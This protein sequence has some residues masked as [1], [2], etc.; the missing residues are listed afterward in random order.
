MFQTI[1][2]IALAAILLGLILFVPPLNTMLYGGIQ[3]IRDQ[4]DTRPERRILFIG[5]SRTFYNDM[6]EMVRQMSGEAGGAERLHIEMYAKSGVSLE[7]HWADPQ[8]QALLGQGWD[9]VV[10]QAQSTAQ[11][12]AQHSGR[13]WQTAEQFIDKARSVGAKPVMFVTWRY[14]AFC[15][16]GM[17]IPGAG[18]TLPASGLPNMHRNIQLQHARLAETTGVELV[19]VGALW[20]SLQDK[21]AIFHLYAD[22]NHPSVYGSY[23][24]ALMFFNYFTGGTVADVAYRPEWMPEERASYIRQFVSAYLGQIDG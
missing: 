19:N 1:R 11:Y 5:N 7:T 9:D 16:P 18:K 23:L 13:L 6:P 3:T 2:T 15:P 4:F 12:D 14:T 17:G 21:A 10:L 24:S 20:E 22:C 8:V